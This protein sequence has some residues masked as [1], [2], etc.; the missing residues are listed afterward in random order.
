MDIKHLE[1][2]EV[3]LGTALYL[4]P[5]TDLSFVQLLITNFICAQH[6]CYTFA[7]QVETGQHSSRMFIALQNKWAEAVKHCIL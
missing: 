1:Y 2:N 7:F 3:A 5:A 6:H 4:L